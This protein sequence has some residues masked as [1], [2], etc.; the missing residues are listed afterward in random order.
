M[1]RW[2]VLLWEVG[3][4]VEGRKRK[5]KLEEIFLKKELI[6]IDS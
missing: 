1:R 6:G 4:V 5:V 2:G 3:G